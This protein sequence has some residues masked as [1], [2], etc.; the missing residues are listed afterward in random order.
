MERMKKNAPT[1]AVGRAIDAGQAGKTEM[2][3]DTFEGLPKPAD[4][5][6]EFGIGRFEE[7]QRARKHA[8]EP[9][10]LRGVSAP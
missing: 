3:V 7:A 9:A 1:E 2:L 8:R 4:S 5:D 10:Q 6:T